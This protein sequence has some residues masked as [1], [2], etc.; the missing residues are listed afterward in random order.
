[1]CVA[2]VRQICEVKPVEKEQQCDAT[3]QRRNS[4]NE[5]GPLPPFGF[6]APNGSS[7][8][9]C[10]KSIFAVTTRLSVFVVRKA[11]GGTAS[12]IHSNY[13]IVQSSEYYLVELLHPSYHQ[14]EGTRL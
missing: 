5:F 1:M 3:D 8:T 11:T 13:L 7:D 2:C 6:L 12:F 4:L 14:F 9:P 10:R